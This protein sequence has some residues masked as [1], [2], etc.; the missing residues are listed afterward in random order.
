MLIRSFGLKNEFKNCFCRFDKNADSVIIHQIMI[1]SCN[2][3]SYIIDAHYW[4][5]Q[6][7]MQLLIASAA[8]HSL[9]ICSSALP[10]CSLRSFLNI[11]VKLCLP[12]FLSF[13]HF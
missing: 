10:L 8:F 4:H 2:I 11:I 9:L 5:T 7:L 13:L 12:F 6:L 1:A 3:Q